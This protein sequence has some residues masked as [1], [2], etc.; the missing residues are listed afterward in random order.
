MFQLSDGTMDFVGDI[1]KVIAP[2][3]AFIQTMRNF[4][5]MIVNDQGKVSTDD[6]RLVAD[7]LKLRPAHHNAWGAIFRGK[8]WVCIGRKKSGYKSNNSREIKIWALDSE[9]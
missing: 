7:E 9:W 4:A 6:L 8:E 3:E 2:N 1:P 5:R